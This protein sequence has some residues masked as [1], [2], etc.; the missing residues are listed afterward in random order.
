VLITRSSGWLP[1]RNPTSGRLLHSGSGTCAPLS[2]TPLALLST[3]ETYLAIPSQGPAL[4]SAV[5]YFLS[6]LS[7]RHESEERK[8]RE[9]LLP[10]VAVR[11]VP[12]WETTP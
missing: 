6:V 8:R 11:R 4:D 5:A 3:I 2:A 10:K 1:R 7:S 12:N 9:Q